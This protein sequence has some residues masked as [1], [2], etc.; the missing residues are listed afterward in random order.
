MS[1]KKFG[2]IVTDEGTALIAECILAGK[3]LP[4]TEAAA[5]DGGGAYYEP[6]ADQI[7]LKGER[8]RG[9][10]AGFALSEYSPNMI[11]VKIVI[12]D[13]V[14]G[15]TIRE[16]G[17]FTDDGILFAVC[18]TPDTEKVSITGGIPGR[19]VMTMH[20]IVADA[21]VVEVVI[22]P[23]LDSVTPEQLSDAMGRIDT[24][25]SEQASEISAAKKAASEAKTSAD[26]VKEQI[27]SGTG[28]T[29]STLGGKTADEFAA[30]DHTHDA[31]DITDM[32]TSLPANGGNADTVGGAAVMTTSALGLRRMASGT[33]A[34]TSATCPAGCWY[35]QYE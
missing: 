17:L 8:W 25:L 33:A 20:I 18:N 16:M 10:I 9:E 35:G 11:D 29:A 5:G 31:S 3:M 26:E 32:P 14:G 34:P 27:G 28:V 15:F 4:I 22:N 6:T 12:D 23:D 7:A 30:A 19:L 1:E 13:A 2:T 24:K 21:S